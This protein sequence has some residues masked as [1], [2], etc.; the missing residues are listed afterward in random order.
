MEI[1]FLHQLIDEGYIY[2]QQHPDSELT[3]YNYSP[4]AQ[5]ERVWNEWTL[6]CRGLIMDRDYQIIARPFRNRKF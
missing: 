3:I 2:A 4:K 1:Q 5:Y 6:L